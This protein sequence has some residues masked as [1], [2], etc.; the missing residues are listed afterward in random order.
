MYASRSGVDLDDPMSTFGPTLATASGF[1]SETKFVREQWFN[2]RGLDETGKYADPSSDWVKQCKASRLIGK[3]ASPNFSSTS[4]EEALPVPPLGSPIGKMEKELASFQTMF[5]SIA[6]ISLRAQE[7]FN[8]I[9]MEFCA[10]VSA[11]G[12][13]SDDQKEA[14]ENIR[15]R[16]LKDVSQ[17]VSQVVR[18]AGHGFNQSLFR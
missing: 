18:V 12:D 16:L 1:Q 3:F 17:N 15:M 6:H 7:N 13:M 10:F 2:L 5:G 11:L 8:N 14:W 4:V 9:Y